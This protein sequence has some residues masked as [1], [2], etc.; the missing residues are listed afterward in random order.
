M[1]NYRKL[2]S[3]GFAAL[4]IIL[5]PLLVM[6]QYSLI[7]VTKEAVKNRE[8][9]LEKKKAL[10]D[11]IDGLKRQT[12]E[13]KKDLDKLAMVLPETK[14]THEVVVNLEEMGKQTGTQIETIKTAQITDVKGAVSKVLQIEVN[15]SGQYKSIVDFTKLLEK[16]LR[17]L[18]MQEFILSLDTS[19]EGTGKLKFIGKMY[20][21]FIK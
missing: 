10:I 18:D 16:N 5:L 21:Y 19:A 8:A 13:K 9:G 20:A 6:P 1:I 12:Q 15:A 11:K 4:G 14:N 3:A 2:I 7:K 17:I